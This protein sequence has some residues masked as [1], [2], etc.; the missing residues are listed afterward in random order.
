MANTTIEQAIAERILVLDGAMGT[1]I[2]RAGLSEADF[3]P[4]GEAA[5]CDLTGCNDLLCLSRPDVISDIHRQYLEAGADIIETNTFN[6]NAVSLAEYGMESRVGEINRAGARI[7]RE[8]A[9]ACG[10]EAWVAGSVGPTGKSLSMELAMNGGETFGFDSLAD[11]YTE[12][13]T[14][15]IE[16]GVDLLMIETQF[17]G[18][19]ARAAVYASRRA[20]ERAGREVPVI[21]SAT[22]TE[23]GRTLSGQSLDAFIASVAHARPLA[24]CLNCGFGVDGMKEHAATLARHPFNTGIYPN[25]GLPNAMGEYD[26]TPEAM[27]ASIATLLDRGLLNLVGGCCGTTPEHIRL[28]AAEARRRRP[29]PVPADDPSTL[30]LAG[31]ELLELPAGSP[32][33]NVGERCNVAGSRKFLR[34]IKEH[35]YDEALEIARSQIAAGA[36]IID[37]NLD[38]AM[39]DARAEMRSLISKLGSDPSTARVPL[40]IDSSDWTVVEEALKCVQGRPVVNSIS[41]KEGEERFLEKARL[42]R[43]MGAA[44][45]VMA[46]DE[47]GQAVDFERKTAICARAYRLLSGQ[48]E[49]KPGDIIFDP[50]ILTVGTGI[51]EHRRY[52]LDFLRATEWIKQNLPGAR[53][54][55]GVSN[56]SF[57]FRGNNPLR[58][59]IHAVFL[60]H[61]VALGM[62]MAI[63]NPSSLIPVQTIDAGMRERIDDLLLDRRHDSVDRLLELKEEPAAASAGAASTADTV[64]V[65]EKIARLVQRGSV[66]GLEALLDEAVCRHSTALSVI[67]NCL[68]PGLNRVG[69][70]FGRGEMFL[71]QVVKSAGVMKAAVAYLTP[72]IEAAGVEAAA[73][74][75]RMTLAT[76]KGDVHDIGKNIL[77]V[78]MQCNGFRI[79]D[80]GV[81]VPAETIL[82]RAVADRADFVGLSGLI[83]PSLGEMC[84]V[85]SMM[86]ERGMTIPLFVGG[87]AASAEHTAVR[88]APC[89]SGPVIYTRDASQLPVVARR[90]L[91]ESTREETLREIRASQEALRRRH[92]GEPALLTLEEARR[93]R[94]EVSDADKAPAPHDSGRHELTVSVADAADWINVRALFAAWHLDASLASLADIDGCDHCRAQWLAALPDEK[95]A[96]GAEAMQLWKQA[97]RMLRS[98]AAEGLDIKARVVLE[99]AR[100]EGEDIIVAD[101]VVIPTLRRITDDGA[102]CPAFA[103]FVAESDDHIGLFAVT[104][105]SGIGRFIERQT[106]DFDRLLAQSLA[107]RLVEAAAEIVHLR[108][109][110]SLW[111]YAPLEDDEPRRLLRAEYQGIRPAIGYPSLPDQSLVF[112]A[113]R[114][115]D[116]GSMGITVT[117]NGALKP[118]ATVTGL[119]IA[120]PAS[121]YFV[122]GAL[123]DE[124][125]E[126]YRRRRGMNEEQLRRFITL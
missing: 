100:R 119:F 14:A 74:A 118:S 90:L 89:Y 17:D 43:E 53:V 1:M 61:A 68:M 69:E 15:L 94:P 126:D 117:E 125:R 6:A 48:A 47:Q 75:P 71:P 65:D 77:A 39:L 34:L 81:M 78:V 98:M 42:A 123:T 37:V 59:A 36:Q 102:P 21:I 44:V 73:D 52:A 32:F 113:D 55:G 4:E 83:T 45:V 46:F 38:D 8:A 76:V 50:N 115:L 95:R 96:K 80:L 7:A 9:D 79:T 121:R 35:N 70:L 40:M 10:R 91:S 120:H 66:Q 124:A 67:D 18:L 97:R 101:D 12:Q 87:A 11:A 114:L 84:H 63:V 109:R 62:D 49:M 22:L 60:S 41:L 28:I 16:G 108:V 103:D 24:V 116:Y 92:N 30:C 51:D 3:H 56:L 58:E 13:M 110:R 104:V 33:V 122:V 19:N 27:A 25:A 5:A 88:I 86:E 20:M 64:S 72:L 82:D 31:L 54:S 106:S 93:R 111:G 26:E 29:R 105:G 23:Q 99:K 57:A 112:V 107:D 85:A 2:Q